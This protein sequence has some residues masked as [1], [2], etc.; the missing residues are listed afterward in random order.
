MWSSVQPVIPI[1]GNYDIHNKLCP[2]LALNWENE[3]TLLGFQIDNRQ[4]KV[5]ENY[6]K[7]YKKDHKISRRWVPYTFSFK[8]RINI[9]KTFLLPQSIHVA[10]VLDPSDS[11]YEIL[12]RLNAVS[13][14]MDLHSLQR[15]GTGFI[16]RFCMDLNLKEV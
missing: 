5:N 6:E 3:F 16:W 11:T 4:K 8:G 13:S 2:E 10:S 14:T 1:G 12:I 9:A 7:C 15:K